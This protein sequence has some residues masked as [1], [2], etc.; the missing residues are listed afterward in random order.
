MRLDLEAASGATIL[1]P[2]AGFPTWQLD[3]QTKNKVT[4]DGVWQGRR[5]I[6][7]D[8]LCG[9]LTQVIDQ[10]SARELVNLFGQLHPGPPAG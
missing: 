6:G 10:T 7:P 8:E 2:S 9:L 5:D 4:M 3:V 1:Q